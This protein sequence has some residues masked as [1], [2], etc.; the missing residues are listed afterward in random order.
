MSVG[1]KEKH[2]SKGAAEFQRLHSIQTIIQRPFTAPAAIISGDIYGIACI[3]IS[4]GTALHG[5]KP[6]IEYGPAT[7]QLG[8]G[9]EAEVLRCRRSCT[10]SAIGLK[11]ERL[12][13][14]IQLTLNLGMRRKIRRDCIVFCGNYSAFSSMSLHASSSRYV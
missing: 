14:V 6:S 2:V 9:H 10:G 1:R 4:C 11:G 5:D 3:A 8:Y 7:R 13:V 12:L